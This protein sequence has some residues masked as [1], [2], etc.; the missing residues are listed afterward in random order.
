MQTGNLTLDHFRDGVTTVGEVDGKR[1][2]ILVGAN[3]MALVI[4]KKGFQ[5]AGDRVPWP[6]P[7]AGEGE[8][9]RTGG[10][11]RPR[12]LPTPRRGT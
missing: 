6:G 10:G 2:G 4:D 12:V 11:A 5:K 1:L 9:R 8:R 7:G 3:P